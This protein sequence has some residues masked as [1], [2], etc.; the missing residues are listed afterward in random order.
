VSP[1][2]DADLDRLR[3]DQPQID[4]RHIA[5]RIETGWQIVA[6]AKLLARK[7]EHPE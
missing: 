1:D 2:P 4:W 7:L 3:A 6:P 5:N